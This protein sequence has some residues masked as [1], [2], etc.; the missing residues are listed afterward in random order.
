MFYGSI[1]FKA[2]YMRCIR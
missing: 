1:T 2:N